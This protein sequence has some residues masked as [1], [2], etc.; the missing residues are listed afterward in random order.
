M[1][2]ADWVAIQQLYEIIP[3][4]TVSIKHRT[5]IHQPMLMTA[6]NLG[7]RF[8]RCSRGIIPSV[9]GL[10]RHFIKQTTFVQARCFGS[11]LRRCN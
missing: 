3:S 10:S 4:L 5:D 1:D 8:R 11:I 6:T 2:N 7:Q 9:I